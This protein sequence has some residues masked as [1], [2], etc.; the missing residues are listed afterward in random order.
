M[1]RK[2]AATTDDTTSQHP[3]EIPCQATLTHQGAVALNDHLPA[4][5]HSF[6]QKSCDK[7]SYA[8]FVMPASDLS[9][10]GQ[11]TIRTRSGLPAVQTCEREGRLGT[12]RGFVESSPTGTRFL[13]LRTCALP[14]RHNQ[15]NNYVV[16]DKKYE[17][18]YVV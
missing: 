4:L 12:S 17:V 16:A 14:T 7:P 8:R 3:T 10:V 1:G 18:T 15:H 9:S 2:Q 6:T 5:C 11:R 13:E